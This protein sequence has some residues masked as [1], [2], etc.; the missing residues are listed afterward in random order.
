M[1]AHG[2]HDKGNRLM[3]DTNWKAFNLI[4]SVP[5][6]ISEVCAQDVYKWIKK[7]VPIYHV[8]V[9]RQSIDKVLHAFLFYREERDKKNVRDTCWKKVVKLFPDTPD[10]VSVK[11]VPIP[12]KAWVEDFII[13]KESMDLLGS[14]L[15]RDLKDLNDFFPSDE[16][17]AS[18]SKKQKRVMDEASAHPLALLPWQDAVLKLHNKGVHV[19]ED[20][21]ATYKSNRLDFL[22]D[23]HQAGFGCLVPPTCKTKDEIFGYILSRTKHSVYLF[24]PTEIL[25]KDQNFFHAIR[26][27]ASGIIYTSRF[28]EK[29][30]IIRNL[31]IIILV[32][33]MPWKNGKTGTWNAWKIH[34]GHLISYKEWYE[35]SGD[36]HD[37]DDDI[38]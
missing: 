10:K 14:T 18:L 32:N 33:S 5:G 23:I 30:E 34:N 27:L 9:L 7:T 26:E 35:R 12:G 2:A 21:T 4:V 6:D 37:E 29:L 3:S 15:P 28:P 31:K 24:S 17:I 22:L 13:R 16:A 20:D 25:S 1:H 19:V 8:A 11:C 38:F 36:A